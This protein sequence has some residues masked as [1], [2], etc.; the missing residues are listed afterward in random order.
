MIIKKI[1]I[2]KY[3][4]WKAR[5][6]VNCVFQNW[7]REKIYDCE[8]HLKPS[9]DWSLYKNLCLTPRWCTAD[10]KAQKQDDGSYKNT[11]CD[12]LLSYSL[13][14]L[15]FWVSS[16]PH[17]ALIQSPW[18]SLSTSISPLIPGSHHFCDYFFPPQ[19][20][21]TLASPCKEGDLTPQISR[22]PV[23]AA[24]WKRVWA[25]TAVTV[26]RKVEKFVKEEAVFG[27]KIVR[28][29]CDSVELLQYSQT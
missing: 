15:M 4:H 18:C 19:L 14:V 9:S 23:P 17:P 8:Q 7:T 28:L 27:L 2:D 10:D 6:R 11:F 16:A 1:L 5:C 26:S 24:K 29:R 12:L 3:S 22:L 20:T 21:P 13:I 25:K